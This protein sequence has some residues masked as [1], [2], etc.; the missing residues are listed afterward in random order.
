M[1]LKGRRARHRAAVRRA[2]AAA[3]VTLGA[4][5]A[6]VPGLVAGP[7]HASPRGLHWAPCDPKSP[8]AE[9]ATLSLPVDWAHP[10]GPAFGVALAR[11]TATG[12]GARVGALVFGPGGPGDSGVDRVV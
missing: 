1:L 2:G 12:P 3:V 5:T 9:C 11:R 6:V 8:G 7:A 4:V 10:D